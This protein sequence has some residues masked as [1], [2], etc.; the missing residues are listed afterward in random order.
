ML[1]SW[2]KSSQY[3]RDGRSDSNER[4]ATVCLRIVGGIEGTFYFAHDIVGN[5]QAVSAIFNIDLINDI[6]G[7][8]VLV[9]QEF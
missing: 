6:S 9:P 7:P 2:Q 3:G 1:H 5:K 4:C 8:G